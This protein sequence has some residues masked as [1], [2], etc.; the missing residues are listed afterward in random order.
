MISMSS[1]DDQYTKWC[2]VAD[3][4]N[5]SS[6]NDTFFEEVDFSIHHCIR[7]YWTYTPMVE[8]TNIAVKTQLLL[9]IQKESIKPTYTENHNANV[10]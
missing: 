4:Y 10:N 8:L 7:E 3:V 5:E 1:A 9:A 6:L 2:R